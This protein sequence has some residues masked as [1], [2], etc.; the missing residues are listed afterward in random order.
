MTTR[1][2]QVEGLELKSSGSCIEYKKV[3]KSC[4]SDK[5]PMFRGPNGEAVYNV[6]GTAKQFRG[7][8]HSNKSINLT[9]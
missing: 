6:F 8:S 9:D 2:V 7:I 1:V 3:S 5:S 4:L